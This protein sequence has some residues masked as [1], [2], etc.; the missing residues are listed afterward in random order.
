[1]PARIVRLFTPARFDTRPGSLG[2]CHRQIAKDL[3]AGLRSRHF[4]FDIVFG[5]SPAGPRL[6][7][8][9]CYAKCYARQPHSSL[10]V[11]ACPGLT[12]GPPFCFTALSG[13]CVLMALPQR[14]WDEWGGTPFSRKES[15][16]IVLVIPPATFLA[17][18]FIVRVTT[19]PRHPSYAPVSCESVGVLVLGGSGH[20][21]WS[22][23]SVP[24]RPQYTLFQLLG[25]FYCLC[26]KKI[27]TFYDQFR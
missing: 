12:P 8:A 25:A 10:S 22:P 13:L 2:T 23:R 21:A 14:R 18:V 4:A 16:S 19:Q 11:P 17:V 15:L 6:L 3:P 20:R 1:M 9:S 7:V 26:K 5:K 27:H 24:S